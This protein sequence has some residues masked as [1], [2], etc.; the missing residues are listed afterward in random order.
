[1]LAITFVFLAAL[2]GPADAKSALRSHA[3]VASQQ[4]GALREARNSSNSSSSSASSSSKV[5]EVPEQIAA[6]KQAEENA[7]AVPVNESLHNISNVLANGLVDGQITAQ[8]W[9]TVERKLAAA[10]MVTPKPKS[11]NDQPPTPKPDPYQKILGASKTVV[12]EDT[13]EL[14][15]EGADDNYELA[16]PKPPIAPPSEDEDDIRTVGVLPYQM[17][18]GAKLL[19]DMS[20]KNTPSPL[21]SQALVD[22]TFNSQCPMIMMSNDI[23]ITP[24]CDGGD[25][26]GA[27]TDLNSDR[28]ITRWRPNG[29]AG[30]SYDVD[31]AVT[32]PGSVPFASLNEKMTMNENIFELYNCVGV[33]RYTVQ[34]TIVK[35]EHMGQRAQSTGVAHD[36]GQ[37]ANAI[38]YQ[39]LI[40]HPNGS[41]AAKSSQ[42]R[43]PETEVNFTTTVP[44][45]IEQPLLAAAKRRGNWDGDSWRQCKIPQAG[46]ALHFPAEKG[47]TLIS[48]STVQDLQVAATAVLTL[49]AYREEHVGSDG[50]EHAGEMDLYWSMFKTVLWIALVMLLLAVCIFVCQRCKFEMKLKKVL[51]RLE[52]IIMPK[53]PL[54]VREPPLKASW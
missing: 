25:G 10:G 37:A 54:T 3:A 19:E 5:Q 26:N 51:L 22:E 36:V 16:T 47:Q 28:I 31:S 23:F 15:A 12:V 50:F 30:L 48:I 38:F 32:G 14:A 45:Q 8:Y 42:Y 27:W 41:I 34:E 52:A 20:E 9:Q 4:V 1:M 11:V 13:P 6:W 24:P 35:V 33:K 18:L 53:S 21:P 7:N 49:M 2:L 39:Y 17:L 43:L 29:K 40:K 46:W 44:G